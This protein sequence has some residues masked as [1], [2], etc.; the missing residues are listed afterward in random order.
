[1]C[2]VSVCVSVWVCSQC[3]GCMAAA[4]VCLLLCIPVTP[5]PI[6]LLVLYRRYSSR[7]CDVYLALVKGVFPKFTS[8]TFRSRKEG[9]AYVPFSKVVRV[10][11]GIFVDD[12]VTIS[13][14]TVQLSEGAWEGH[15]HRII[16]V[17]TLVSYRAVSRRARARIGHAHTGASPP[18][19][20]QRSPYVLCPCAAVPARRSAHTAV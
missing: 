13:L 10:V 4:I 11:A 14:D 6:R 15:Y 17:D 9:A 20:P 5:P 12:P 18:P 2:R 7:L 1:M 19:P 16:D 3:P 8:N